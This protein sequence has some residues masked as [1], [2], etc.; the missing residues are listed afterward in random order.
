MTIP[1]LCQNC[2][3]FLYMSVLRLP[4]EYHCHHLYHTL[5]RCS[6]Q[7]Q[8]CYC[9]CY[10]LARF[11]RCPDSLGH[12][13]AE[14]TVSH[15]VLLLKLKNLG[16]RLSSVNWFRSYLTNRRQVTT[17]GDSV[18]DELQIKCG[19]P[20]GS[21]LGP[22]LFICYI[23]DVSRNCIMTTPFVY[24]DDTALLAH[25][26]G[27][28]EIEG[29]LQSD[30]NN[31]KN[32]F[33]LNKLSLNSSKTKSM[34]LCGRRSRL[35][36][37]VLNINIDGT[38]VECVSEMKYLG[39]T[40]DRH[41]T[42]EHHVNKLCGKVSSRTGL[43]WRIRSFINKDLALLLYNS[44]IFPHLLYANFILDGCSKGNIEKLKVEQ[45][46]AVRAVLQAD[47]RTP[48]VKLYQDAKVD[49]IDVCM[50]KTVCKL[51]YKGV[52]NIGAP[53]YNNM[54]Q[55]ETP[56]HNLRSNDKL[57]AEIPRTNT[58]FGEHNVAYRGPVYW[59]HLPLNIKSCTS[60]EQLK[61]ALRDYA[62]FHLC[63]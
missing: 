45:N 20:Q 4:H 52:N 21:I 38:A 62:G 40:V 18:S 30:I 42:F 47:Y 10:Y 28:A 29:K 37:E 32:W 19:V 50:K 12:Y 34:L 7:F 15:D 17:V 8:V 44:L 60:F 46:N 2:G 35:K 33:Q 63:N 59:N 39:L 6:H 57:L 16:F 56:T 43:L 54:F 1:Q 53:V 36:S 26:H 27:V 41:L 14:W 51:V 49:P 61:V 48:C 24:A 3:G 13:Y 5:Q 31:L 23:N 58:K 22:L 25:G 55:Y 11:R 9:L